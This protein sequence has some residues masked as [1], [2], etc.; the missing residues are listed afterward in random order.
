MTH[1]TK[2]KGSTST[3]SFSPSPTDSEANE[4]TYRVSRVIR[5]PSYNKRTLDYDIAILRLRGHTRTYPHIRKE[6]TK[7]ILLKLSL[8]SCSI[9]Q[10]NLPSHGLGSHRSLGNARAHDLKPSNFPTF[11]S[12]QMTVAGWGVEKEDEDANAA[13]S[14][15]EVP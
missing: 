6:R 7:R 14:L 1:C 12:F 8:G 9:F 4:R 15:K 5:H 11:R 10:T 2:I 3:L 13:Y